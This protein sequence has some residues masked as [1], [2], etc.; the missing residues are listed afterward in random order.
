MCLDIDGD[1][2]SVGRRRSK[3]WKGVADVDGMIEGGEGPLM[4][5]THIQYGNTYIVQASLT[6]HP[7]LGIQ[8]LEVSLPKKKKRFR[9]LL[10]AGRRGESFCSGSRGKHATSSAGKAGKPSDVLNT[11]PSI[12]ARG[13][14]PP[15]PMPTPDFSA[16]VSPDMN[17]VQAR[18]RRRLVPRNGSGSVPCDACDTTARL[19]ERWGSSRWHDSRLFSLLCAEAHVPSPLQNVLGW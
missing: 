19:D 13:G 1:L 17:G 4:V 7:P 2:T 3:R 18:H 6:Y 5:P 11:V 12:H 16:K 14:F 10:S 15:L 8:M 9:A